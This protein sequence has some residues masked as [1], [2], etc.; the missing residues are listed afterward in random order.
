MRFRVPLLVFLF[1]VCSFVLPIIAHAQGIPFFGPIIPPAD[2]ACPAGWNMLIIV[3]NRIISLL[4]TLAIVF[5]APLMIAYSGFLFLVNPVDSSG[6]TKA[7]GILTNTIVG[8]VIALA[9]WMIV[10]AIMAV[11]Y[12][13]PND[14]WGT[15]TSLIRGGGNPCLDQSGVTPP[16]AVTPPPTVGVVPKVTCETSHTSNLQTLAQYGITVSS[17]GNCCDRNNSRCTSLAGMSSLTLSQIINIKNKCG[18]LTVTG[19]T[20]V[21]HSSEG[22]A[23]SHSSGTKVDVSQNLIFCISGTANSFRII[24]PSFGASQIR[25]KCGNI[26]TWEGN[27]TDIYMRAACVL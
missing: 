14:S 12:R 1:T 5:V 24:P 13:S 18:P 2:N 17:S 3:I 10:A 6:I 21:G 23:G 19:G 8:I 16:S 26:Y 9:G 27:H 25:D 20:E 4:L 11:L 15:W 7:K 22:G